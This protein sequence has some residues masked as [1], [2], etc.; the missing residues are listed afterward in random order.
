MEQAKAQMEA[1]KEEMQ[2]EMRSIAERTERQK[3]ALVDEELSAHLVISLLPWPSLP[4]P[5]LASLPPELMGEK[6]QDLLHEMRGQAAY[7][8]KVLSDSNETSAQCAKV[9]LLSASTP[10]MT[11][12]WAARDRPSGAIRRTS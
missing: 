3:E 6:G 10:S 2:D 8:L 12:W 11:E 1:M 5:G 7:T 4:P 9:A